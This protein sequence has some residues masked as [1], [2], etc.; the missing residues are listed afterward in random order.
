MNIYKFNCRTVTKNLDVTATLIEAGY[1]RWCY[2]V[3]WEP[4]K[5]DRE[6]IEGTLWIH[7]AEEIAWTYAHGHKIYPGPDQDFFYRMN[8]YKKDVLFKS[9]WEQV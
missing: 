3:G 1:I 2:K 8:P 7:E 4:K 6:L 5:K 9:A